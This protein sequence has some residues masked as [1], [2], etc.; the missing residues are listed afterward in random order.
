MKRLFVSLSLSVALI[1]QVTSQSSIKEMSL[2]QAAAHAARRERALQRREL[3]RLAREL[4]RKEKVP[5]LAELF[6]S[7]NLGK[8][9]VGALGGIS[10]IAGVG[11]RGRHMGAA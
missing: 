11:Q 2:S 6:F 8:K 9:L 7:R 3:F 4:L 5:L 1:G 10:Q